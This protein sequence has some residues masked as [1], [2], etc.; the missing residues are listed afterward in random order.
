MKLFIK[1]YDKFAVGAIA[2]MVMA[3]TGLGALIQ[4][5]LEF[6]PHWVMY[7][8]WGSG[9]RN[10]LRNKSIPTNRGILYSRYH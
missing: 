2:A 10:E 7:L 5:A 6:S 1:L 3:I 9:I 8:F 4:V